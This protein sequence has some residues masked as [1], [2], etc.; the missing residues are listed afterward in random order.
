MNAFDLKPSPPRMIF[1]TD[2]LNLSPADTLKCLVSLYFLSLFVGRA[3]RNGG[4]G[5]GKVLWILPVIHLKKRRI[6][7][8]LVLMVFRFNS[9]NKNNRAFHKYKDN[10]AMTDCLRAGY[11]I[12]KQ[13]VIAIFFVVFIVC[14]VFFSPVVRA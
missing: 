6:D 11:S 14:S 9:L 12:T 3:R 2:W 8:C 13:S 5:K 10:I 1:S 7:C 4:S